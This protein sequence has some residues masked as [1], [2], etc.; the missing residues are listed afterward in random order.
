MC[1]KTILLQGIQL[2]VVH[3]RSEVKCF[4]IEE[5]AKFPISLKHARRQSSL[6]YPSF[7]TNEPYNW[8]YKQNC[9]L[10]S[11]QVSNLSFTMVSYISTLHLALQVETGGSPNATLQFSSRARIEKKQAYS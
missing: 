10:D 4:F 6:F 5:H 3:I 1:L 8:P 11:E 9:W 7:V 2:D